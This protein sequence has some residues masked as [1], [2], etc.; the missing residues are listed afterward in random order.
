M[1]ENHQRQIEQIKKEYDDKVLERE[2]F[3]SAKV[4]DA[5][6]EYEAKHTKLIQE[7]IY[8]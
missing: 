5:R 2:A 6:A 4:D 7:Y 8:K 1:L 3:F